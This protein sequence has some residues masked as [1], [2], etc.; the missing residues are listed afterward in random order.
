MPFSYGLSHFRLYDEIENCF[1]IEL[2][3]NVQPMQTN[4]TTEV[5]PKI[6]VALHILEYLF[7]LLPIQ[8]GTEILIP[9]ENQFK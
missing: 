1:L 4:E 6:A 7:D 2:N 5:F 9:E 8:T 3:D